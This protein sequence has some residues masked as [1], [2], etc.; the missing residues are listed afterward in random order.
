MHSSNNLCR[1]DEGIE[2]MRVGGKRRLRIPADLAYGDQRVGGLDM[3]LEKNVA[4]DSSFPRCLF[5]LKKHPR[6]AGK[7][8]RGI[9]VLDRSKGS[10]QT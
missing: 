7:Q 3:D 2:G 1:W 4:V 6:K 8:N 9:Q 5:S 10:V